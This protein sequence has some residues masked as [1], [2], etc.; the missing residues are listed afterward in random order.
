MHS[1]MRKQA[2]AATSMVSFLVFCSTL[3]AEPVRPE[4]VR[5]VAGAFLETRM[6]GPGTGPR[7]FSVKADATTAPA[8]L[9]EIRDDDGTVLAY[10]A[11]LEPA[12]YVAIS[13]DTD[14]APIIAYSL[15]SSFPSEKDGKNPLYRLLR[16]DMRLRL[17]ALAEYDPS[18]AAENNTLW[19]RYRRDEGPVGETFQQW[20]QENT[21]STG[22]WLQTAWDQSEPYNDLCPLDPVD[23]LRSVVGCVATAM[24]QIVNYHQL[25]NAFF[26]AEDTYTTYSGIAIDADS[27]R[28]DFPSL[29]ELNEHLTAIRLKYGRQIELDDTDVAALSFACGV[30]VKMDYSSEGSGAHFWDM[31]EAMLDKFGFYSAEMTGGLSPEFLA[32]LKEDIVNQVPAIIGINYPTEGGGHAIICDG[33]NTNGEYH[34]NFGWGA[35]A[36]DEITEAWYYLPV[37][38]PR[39]FNAVDELIVNVRSVPPGIEIDPASVVF[40]TAPGQESEAVAV[41]LKNNTEGPLP[42]NSIRSPEGFVVS[43]SDDDYADQIAPFT[44]E[45]PGQEIAINVRFRSQEAGSTHGVLAVSYGHD[46]T[47]YAV[48]TGSVVEGGTEVEAGDVSGIWSEAESPYYVLGDISV[49]DSGELIIEPGVRVIFTGPYSLTVGEEARLVAEGTG[50]GPIEFTAAN[51]ELGWKGLRFVESGED[52]VLRY[53]SITFSKKGPAPGVESGASTRGG[54]IYCDTS[55]PSITHCKITNNTGDSAGAIYSLDSDLVISNTVV[56]NNTAMGDFPQCGGIYCDGDSSLQLE[57]CTIVNNFPGAVLSDAY[58]WV[59]MVNTIVWGN[60]NYQIECDKSLS[61]V[62]CCDVQDGYPG[63]GNIDADPCFFDP[64]GGI[65]ADYDGSAANWALKSSSPCINGGIDLGPAEADVAGNPRLH[66]DLVD[67]GAYENQ[68]ELPLM[69]LEPAS[70]V[71]AGPVAIDTESTVMLDIIN[72][73]TVDFRIESLSLSD[74]NSAFFVVTPIND[75]VLAPDERISVEIGIAPTEE[76]IYSDTLHIHSTSSNGADRTAELRGVGVL[77][78][79]IPAGEVRGTWTKAN[80]P[81]AVT[82]DIEVQRG[83]TLTIEPGVVVKF[84]GH[85]GMT[86]GNRA[87]LR[88]IGTE[89]EPIVFTAVDVN[90]GWYGMRFVD[91]GDDDILQYCTIEY[92]TKPDYRQSNWEDAWGGGILCGMSYDVTSVPSSPTIDHCVIANNYAYYGGAILCTDDCEAVITHNRIVNNSALIVAGI[93]VNYSSPTIANNVIAHNSADINGGGIYNYE[94]TPSIINNTIAHNRPN[95]LDF[96]WVSPWSVEEP[97]RV[98]NNIVWENEI[99]FWDGVGLDQYD[100]R[101]NDIQGGWE[102]EDEEEGEDE[103]EGEEEKGNIGE[104]PLFADSENMDYHLKSEAGRWDPASGSWIADGVTSPCIDAGNPE[105]AVGE[106]PDSNGERVNM[107]AYGGTTQASK[108]PR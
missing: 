70:I 106:E 49:S 107:G 89:L 60:G 28:Y 108:S 88:A 51:R 78:T 30:A 42:I 65:G 75:H 24:V 82:G 11:E 85:Y 55:A 18:E 94:G 7:V 101:F 26:D 25:C 92:A 67:I 100:I 43:L 86:V 33:Y 58:F 61:I 29:E 41:F 20:P 91:A 36:P 10:I 39:S 15:H 53:C 72:T 93:W 34:L 44:I 83:R 2:L 14:I 5:R 102:E 59:E 35:S 23:G 37:E 31:H 16:E 76:K 47:K 71:D 97:V 12:G 1:F 105:T 79:I 8:G 77:G 13:A 63:E 40:R 95:G 38:I 66:S 45:R 56:A 81:Y 52:D 96:D 6:A 22:G 68:S 64:S 32:V 62:T 69:T 98:W 80:A 46:R 17:Q 21:T 73:G 19:A 3:T 9:R 99:Y 48:L 74:P 4:Q 87:T 90:E 27:D 84:T 57:N 104:D 50:S 103:G 54:A